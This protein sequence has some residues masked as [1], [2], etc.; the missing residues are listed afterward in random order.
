ME[1]GSCA[2]AQFLKQRHRAQTAAAQSLLCI[3]QVLSLRQ[4]R[5]LVA[6]QAHGASPVPVTSCR[7]LPAVQSVAHSPRRSVNA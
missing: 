2:C 4:S 5:H 3:K 1:F 7:A 6:L